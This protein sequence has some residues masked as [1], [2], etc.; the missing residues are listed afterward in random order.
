MSNNQNSENKSL[1]AYAS[2]VVS[3]VALPPAINAGFKVITPAVKKLYDPTVP[4]HSPL[5]QALQV[6]RNFHGLVSEA[7]T[8]RPNY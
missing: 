4:F 3:D 6:V 8:L 5:E 7:E 2:D 1:I